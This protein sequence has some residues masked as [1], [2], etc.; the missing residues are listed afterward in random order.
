[1]FLYDPHAFELQAVAAVA[2]DPDIVQAYHWPN[3]P[4]S[5]LLDSGYFVGGIGEHRRERLR[6]G[7][8]RDYGLDGLAQKRSGAY[9]GIQAKAYGPSSVITFS[10]LGTFMGAVNAIRARNPESGGILVHTPEAHIEARLALNLR[11]GVANITSLAL[12]FGG[13]DGGGGGF[14]DPS[15]AA[16]ECEETRFVLRPYQVRAVED[17]VNN[18]SKVALYVSP[19]GTGKTLVIGTVLARTQ[20]DI[21]VVASPLQISAEQN[22]DRLGPFLPGHSVVRAWSDAGCSTQEAI[23]REFS[24]AGDRVIVS[25]TFKTLP[26]VAK[27]LS[28]RDVGFFLIVDEA[29]NLRHDYETATDFDADSDDTSMTDGDDDDTSMTNGDDGDTSMTDDDDDSTPSEDT[30]MTNGYSVSDEASEGPAADRCL[31]QIIRAASRSILMTATPPVFLTEDNGDVAVAHR[32]SFAEAIA[33]KAICDYRMLIPE[34]SPRPGAA[35][36][37]AGESV[38]SSVA[39][40]ASFLAS[41]MLETG[42]R[43]C[44]VYCG[45]R[46]ECAE[47]NAAFEQTCEEYYGVGAATSCI[48]CDTPARER[49]ESLRAFREGPS[50]EARAALDE[51]GE[52][53]E[54]RKTVLRVVSSVRILDESIDIPEC[55]SVFMTKCSEGGSQSSARAVQRVCR[56]TRVSAGKS[57]ASVFV[58]TLD[59]GDDSGLVRVFS[60]L[61]E[62]DVDFASKV[63]PVSWDYDSKATPEAQEA[64]KATVADFNDTFLVRAVTLGQLWETRLSELKAFVVE[65]K[66]LPKYNVKPLGTWIQTQRRKKRKAMLSAREIAALEA[67]PYWKWKENEPFTANLAKLLESV[68]ANGRLPKISEKPLGVWVQTQRQKKKKGKLSDEEIAALNAV[69]YWEWEEKDPFTANLAK[70]LDFVA[71]N[72]R[73][74]KKSDGSLGAW[75]QT[76]RKKKKKGKLSAEEIAA[77]NAL[78]YWKW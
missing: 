52:P 50:S 55:D 54:L 33:D 8:Y 17:I 39:A 40:K 32:Y 20:P 58:W 42:A 10:L 68:A 12:A 35:P 74:P 76:Q 66:R 19:C 75:V 56:A 60:L 53:I 23:E 38:T 21:V 73:L 5:A 24:A 47:F 25:T 64:A 30:S 51:S 9:I 1:M 15:P 49:R 43:R 59:S 28:A 14:E 3:V 71:A 31:W 6:N 57:T 72:G 63:V 77:L 44:I 70:L 2:S 18:D 61:R 16:A 34:I 69:P 22:A 7:G 78:P 65:S 27:A 41:G 67:V 13:S 36:E 37:V 11:V 62:N 48:T 4:E 45:S 29:H 46:A 26:I